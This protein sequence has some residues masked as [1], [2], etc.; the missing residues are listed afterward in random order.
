M[1]ITKSM[2][3]RIDPWGTPCFIIPQFG[4]KIPLLDDF[5]SIFFFLYLLDRI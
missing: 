5:I 2:G 4:K 1:H 3:P